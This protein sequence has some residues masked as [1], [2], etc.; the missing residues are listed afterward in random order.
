MDDFF[1]YDATQNGG[2][3]VGAGS[4]TRKTS[5]STGAPAVSGQFGKPGTL[6]ALPA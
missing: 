4:A 5:A 2:V 3:Y 1:A 6:P